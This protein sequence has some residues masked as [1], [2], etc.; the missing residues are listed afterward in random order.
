MKILTIT[1]ALD[2]QAV[3]LGAKYN[4]QSQFRRQYSVSAVS[5]KAE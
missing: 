4:V 2:N 5:E 1:G 3:S